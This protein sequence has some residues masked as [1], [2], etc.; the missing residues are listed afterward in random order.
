MLLN[1]YFQF[2]FKLHFLRFN[3]SLL[4]EHDLILVIY[5]LLV[6]LY[7]LV[8]YIFLSIQFLCPLTLE[9][10]SELLVI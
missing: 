3:T 1:F 4:L 9:I 2:P 5:H 6:L 8:N 10:S 7:I